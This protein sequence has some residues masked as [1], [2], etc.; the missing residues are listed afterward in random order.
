MFN[1][2]TTREYIE[3]LMRES[4]REQDTAATER[5][6][7]AKALAQEQARAMDQAEREREKAAAVMRGNLVHSIREGDERLREH[8][9][10]QVRQIDAALNSAEKLEVQRMVAGEHA[11]E[12][13]RRELL[14]ITEA[15]KAAVQKAEHAQK[16]VNEKSNEFRGQLSDQAA[17]LYPRKEAEGRIAELDRR[18]QILERNQSAT[19]GEKTGSSTTT[20]L[21]IAAATIFIALAAVLATVLSSHP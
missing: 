20:S 4:K 5:E 7:A 9:E 3:A 16:E 2:V 14:L 10:N 21:L 19:S 18:I 1:G 12:S 13:V 17:S 8:I 15:S 11:T 6:K